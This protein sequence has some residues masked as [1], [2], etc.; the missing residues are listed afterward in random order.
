MEPSLAPH[1]TGGGGSFAE[2]LLGISSSTNVGATKEISITN[3]KTSSIEVS[4]E[5]QVTIEEED[6]S[7]TL[8]SQDTMPKKPI[9]KEEGGDKQWSKLFHDNRAPSYGL[10]LEYFPP[11]G[12]KLDFSHLKVPS[13]I[14]VWGYCLVGH[15][16]GRFPGMK[17]IIAMTKAW[18]VEVQVK[19]HS[20]GWV[21]FKFPCEVDRTKVLSE[22]PYVLYGKTMFLK[23]LSED[24]SVDSDEFLKVPTWVK[25]P[26]LPMRLW[27][28]NEIGRIA[29]MVGVPITTDKITQE[30]TYTSFA[31]VLIEIDASKQ[32]VLQF[33]I[34]LPSGKEHTQ[35]VIYETYPNF[36]YHCKTFG[37]HAF[38]CNILNPRK[39]VTKGGDTAKGTT[40]DVVKANMS[41]VGANK[42]K[43]IVAN[44]PAEPPFQTVQSK[45]SRYFF[46]LS[47]SLALPSHKR[48]TK[49]VFKEGDY[50]WEGRAISSV[51][52]MEPDDIV[53]KFV[54]NE[55]GVQEVFVKKRHQIKSI[56]SVARIGM[57]LHKEAKD[58]EPG[59]FFTDLCLTSLPGVKRARRWYAFNKPLFI[60]KVASF[61][62]V[63]ARHNQHFLQAKVLP[64]G[65]ATVDPKPP[66]T[67]DGASTSKATKPKPIYTMLSMCDPIT[68]EEG[69]QTTIEDPEGRLIRNMHQMYDDD[70][71][72]GFFKDENDKKV[73]FVLP[74]DD[75]DNDEKVVKVGPNLQWVSCEEPG[76]FFTEPC[77][78]SLPTVKKNKDWYDFDDLIFTNEVFNFFD[79]NTAWN[80]KYFKE[81]QRR[82][83]KEARDKEK[84][85]VQPGDDGYTSDFYLS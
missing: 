64:K 30:Q 51:H 21:I 71:V 18:E 28:A 42:G 65:A 84:G 49:K 6:E 44:E 62:D 75:V 32:P 27:Q 35:R 33:P 40:L 19:T 54:T 61:F 78:L 45:N 10:K 58:S 11:T 59:I 46:K 24:F 20:K 73:D 53:N 22:G 31:R 69:T 8:G 41:Q 43:A 16:S 82:K 67:V 13:L 74:L 9:E 5:N 81:M 79:A 29:S 26:R 3:A 14:E 36:C 2:A 57:V 60:A 48:K 63:N 1:T 66:E 39:E 37:H 85:A 47:A 17:A 25:F 12:E 4:D 55:D 70:V 7:I 38:T 77:L 83:R 68:G 52:E 23:E 15:F 56:Y 50:E 34:I 72:T 76:V 80:K